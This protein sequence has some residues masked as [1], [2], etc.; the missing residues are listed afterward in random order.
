MKKELCNPLILI[1]IEEQKQEK[2]IN[3]SPLS[4]IDL[5]SHFKTKSLHR[6]LMS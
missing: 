6:V 4:Y 2:K 1:I 5:K 3:N